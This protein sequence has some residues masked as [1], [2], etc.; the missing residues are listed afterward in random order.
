MASGK[1]E[2]Q[3]PKHWHVIAYT[4]KSLVAVSVLPDFSLMQPLVSGTL[5]RVV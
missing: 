5:G 2:E 4:A 3:S 1:L